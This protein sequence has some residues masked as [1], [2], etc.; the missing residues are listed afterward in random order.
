MTSNQLKLKKIYT[1]FGIILFQNAIKALRNCYSNLNLQV[2]PFGFLKDKIGDIRV[3]QRDTDYYLP[4]TADI[5]EMI[6]VIYQ[7]VKDFKWERE[8]FDCDDRAKTVSALFSLIFRTNCCGEAYCSIKG[9]KTYYHWTNILVS[10]EGD[11]ILF[12]VDNGGR[13]AIIK[14]I[15]SKIHLGKFDYTFFSVRF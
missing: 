10:K 1:N 4:S 14:D 15:K 11:V 7:L 5:Y 2:K 12:D 13:T 6:K 9:K 8:T 3:I